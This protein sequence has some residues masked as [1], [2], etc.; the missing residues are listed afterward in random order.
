MEN[1]E[2]TILAIETS[3]DETA[4]AVIGVENS[5]PIILSTVI[6]SSAD[7]HA[8]TGGI[9]PEVASRA[10]MEAMMP[11]IELALKQANSK[12]KIQN[13]KLRNRNSQNP[14]I[15]N[16]K[17]KIENSSLLDDIT[18]VAVTNGPGLIGSLLVG[19]NAAKTIAYARK[20]PFI[21]INHIEGHIYS[22]YAESNPKS[23]ILISKQIPNSK[24]QNNNLAIEQLSNNSKFPILALTVS[25]GHTSLTVMRDHGLYET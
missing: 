17:L 6:S 2:T 8:K 21:P 7:L 20:L 3:C 18:H 25:G 4:A 22:A 14:D 15:E 12:F 10:Q 16:S 13:L 5:K 1:K 11:V 23:E 24:F 19:F 9:V